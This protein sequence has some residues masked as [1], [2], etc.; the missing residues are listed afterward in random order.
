[1]AFNAGN[2][3]WLFV[4]RVASDSDA[5]STLCAEPLVAGVDEVREVDWNFRLAAVVGARRMKVTVS[6]SAALRQLL[7][8]VR[9]VLQ[10][11]AE[12]SE[13]H[14]IL[15][16]RFNLKRSNKNKHRKFQANA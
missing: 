6:T 12:A 16:I 7:G 3:K 8:Q 14:S 11:G 5:H 1:M 13:T 9:R 4:V 2:Q 10:L 15:P